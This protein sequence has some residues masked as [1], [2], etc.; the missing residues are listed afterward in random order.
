M[1]L[2]F[3]NNGGN[4]NSFYRVVMRGTYHRSCTCHVIRYVSSKGSPGSD[5]VDLLLY[6]FPEVWKFTCILILLTLIL[7]W[8]RF[9]IFMPFIIVKKNDAVVPHPLACFSRLLFPRTCA[10]S[11][12]CE[13]CIIMYIEDIHFSFHFMIFVLR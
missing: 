6:L 10:N 7:L 4:T 8:V 11:L 5:N 12:V 3:N 1:V 13:L 9:W 2:F